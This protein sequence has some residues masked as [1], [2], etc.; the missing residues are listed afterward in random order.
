ML[1]ACLSENEKRRFES[2]LIAAVSE[3]N[4]ITEGEQDA[5]VR[6]RI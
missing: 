5:L 2:L 6:E 1:Y 4:S 3:D